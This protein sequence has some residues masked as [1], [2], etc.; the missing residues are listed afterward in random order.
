MRFLK[1]LFGRSRSLL[2]LLCAAFTLSGCVRYDVGIDFRSQTN[3]E[4][5]Q[6]IRL[7]ERL[8]SFS[9]EE[10]R[11]WTNSIDRRARLLHG[12]TRRLNA[13]SLMV[14]IPFYNAED[15]ESKFDTFFNGENAENA[16]VA[17]DIESDLPQLAA[18]L[19]VFQSNAIFALRNHLELDLDLR[20]LGA[21]SSGDTV[22]VMPDSLLDLRFALTAPWGSRSIPNPDDPIVSK[23]EN[24]QLIWTLKPGKVN[25]IEAVFWVPS[26]IGIG[27]AVVIALA[28]GLS[29]IKKR[30]SPSP[31]PTAGEQKD[32]PAT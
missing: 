27:A 23:R 14:T 28:V 11:E 17:G 18:D 6:N 5:V 22:I 21:I 7:S 1:W 8:T 25:H 19:N 24:G 29:A 10:V 30:I 2:I 26:P 15:L 20:S 13:G 9:D 32:V 12:K 31:K 4:I 3:G 16:E